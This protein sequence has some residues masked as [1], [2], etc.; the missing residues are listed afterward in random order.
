MYLQN[1]CTNYITHINR[2][3]E[4]NR[5]IVRMPPP[6]PPSPP[7]SFATLYRRN[8]TNVAETACV[9]YTYTTT[10]HEDIEKNKTF[11]NAEHR[12]CCLPYTT[13]H[14]YILC[15]AFSR[16]LY[17][18]NQPSSSVANNI[19]KPTTYIH[20][21]QFPWAPTHKSTCQLSGDRPLFGV[22]QAAKFTY[23]GFVCAFAIT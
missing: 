4:N 18:T 11:T 14:L 8:D 6:T 21:S 17:R 10:T 9:L 1:A 12:C 15:I 19:D 20:S 5:L 13:L 7:H 2:D 23:D 16:V 3:A 22:H